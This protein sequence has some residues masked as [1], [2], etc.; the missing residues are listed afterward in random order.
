VAQIIIPH[1]SISKVTSGNF[2][3]VSP[4]VD[5]YACNDSNVIKDGIQ[6]QYSSCEG[7][8]C[9]QKIAVTTVVV[10]IAATAI[11]IIEQIVW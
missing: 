2:F 5:G 6:N 4:R 9:V 8:G 11:V 10:V 3:S 1:S 7:R